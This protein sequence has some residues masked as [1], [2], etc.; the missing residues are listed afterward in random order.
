V[1]PWL[2]QLWMDNYGVQTALLYLA[3]MQASL[4]AISAVIVRR[5]LPT[6]AEWT[7]VDYGALQD[8]NVRLLVAAA[9]CFAT[10]A[11]VAGVH[12]AAFLVDNGHSE[13][14]AAKVVSLFGVGSTV[15]RLLA[16]I[17]ADYLGVLAT[18]RI[19]ILGA[20]CISCMWPVCTT[21]PQASAFAAAYSC[22]A[23][24]WYSLLPPTVALYRD[25]GSL[26]G[27]IGLIFV[28]FVP[29][30]VSPALAGWLRDL[31]GSYLAAQ[32]YAAA[33]L[34]ATGGVLCTLPTPIAARK[35]GPVGI[36]D[37]PVCDMD[38]KSDFTASGTIGSIEKPPAVSN[39]DHA[40][41]AVQH[42]VCC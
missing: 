21:L 38:H 31:T 24:G 42:R 40:V 12:M 4:F 35:S 5:R 2:L 6:T 23:F 19:C 28:G 25:P 10:G 37:V 18:F 29:A 7:A 39:D 3:I 8:P 13:S 32:A 26:A 27:A 11:F 17:V 15:G 41:C 20:A 22:L 33:F 30:A 9:A 1:Y 34:F 36:E 16:G 14:D